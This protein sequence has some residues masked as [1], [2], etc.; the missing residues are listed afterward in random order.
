MLKLDATGPTR[1]QFVPDRLPKWKV[2]TQ[3]PTCCAPLL[4]DQ[5]KLRMFGMLLTLVLTAPIASGRL[6]CQGEMLYPANTERFEKLYIQHLKLVDTFR[7]FHPSERKYSSYQRLSDRRPNWV[8]PTPSP[9]SAGRD[10]YDTNTASKYFAL[11]S[12]AAQM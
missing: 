2:W 9:A 11:W 3:I 10:L 5:G 6:D 8:K 12:A 7:H 4:S 1:V